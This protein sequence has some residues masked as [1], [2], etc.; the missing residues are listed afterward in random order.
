MFSVCPD[1]LGANSIPATAASTTTTTAEDLLFHFEGVQRH[2]TSDQT[3]RRQQVDG[4]VQCKGDPGG[5]SGLRPAEVEPVLGHGLHLCYHLPQKGVHRG[6]NA[7][8]SRSTRLVDDD[9]DDYYSAIAALALWLHLYWQVQQYWV[10]NYII[11]G[12]VY[13]MLTL[14]TI[15]V[16]LCLRSGSIGRFD[17]EEVV[18]CS[19]EFLHAVFQF[20]LVMINCWPM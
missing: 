8:A 4:V 14:L 11:I 6:W 2:S 12:W 7:D 16:N 15:Y 3:A 10:N 1:M 5:S 19:H 9:D 17:G 20:V 13:F 18:R